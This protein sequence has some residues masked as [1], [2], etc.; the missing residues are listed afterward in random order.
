MPVERTRARTRGQGEHPGYKPPLSK[1]ARKRKAQAQRP[2][3]PDS[4]SDSPIVANS[5]D[6]MELG[7]GSVQ[8]RSQASVVK[9]TS[10]GLKTGN[11]IPPHPS[12][13]TKSRRTYSRV[14]PEDGSEPVSL[15][16]AANT[17]PQAW[18]D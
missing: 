7:E 13:E 15:V 11:Y 6:K 10:S 12:V 2:P 16:P 14:A 8:L 3:K 4:E 1:R 18:A 17:N 9:E 5:D